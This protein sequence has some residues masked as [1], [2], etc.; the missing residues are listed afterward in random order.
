VSE[1]VCEQLGTPEPLNYREYTT[2]CSET[3]TV[4]IIEMAWNIEVFVRFPK[5]FMYGP[6][7]GGWSS[8]RS[9]RER[10]KSLAESQTTG[11]PA[12]EMASNNRLYSQL[13]NA[14]RIQG[15]FVGANAKRLSCRKDRM[16]NCLNVPVLSGY[17]LSMQE[18]S[19][20]IKRS[21]RASTIEFLQAKGPPRLQTSASLAL[22]P[23]LRRK[24]STTPPASTNAELSDQMVKP[25]ASCELT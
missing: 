19:V 20:P 22:D 18:R 15:L 14:I 10:H 7:S 24:P 16:S 13:H 8:R 3:G 6:F 4:A 9:L 17:L 2:S 1:S 11:K 12:V 23:I 5:E 25:E 21:Q